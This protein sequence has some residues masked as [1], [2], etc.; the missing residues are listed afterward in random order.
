MSQHFALCPAVRRPL[1]LLSRKTKSSWSFYV[2][3]KKNVGESLILLGISFVMGRHFDALVKSGEIVGAAE[4]EDGD[5]HSND[6]DFGD[7]R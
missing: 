7:K 6:G 2:E 3:T 1:P 5:D 4:D